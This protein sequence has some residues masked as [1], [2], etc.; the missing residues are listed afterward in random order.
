MTQVR[1]IVPPREKHSALFMATATAG[2][3]T[4]RLSPIVQKIEIQTKKE[5]FFHGRFSLT[6]GEM[7]SRRLLLFSFSPFIA[8]SG[9]MR[10]GKLSSLA[11]KERAPT[12]EDVARE[13]EDEVETWVNECMPCF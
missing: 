7:C 4:R 6:L 13:C 8:S 5:K 10:Q 11:N 12:E 3:T 2:E 1:V 9:M